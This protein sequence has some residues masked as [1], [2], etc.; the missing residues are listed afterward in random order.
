MREYLFV[1]LALMLSATAGAVVS[2]YVRDGSSVLWTYA[3]AVV[4]VSVW[5]WQS[6]YSK[7]S[8]TTAS[9][10]FDFV[11]NVTWFVTLVALGETIKPVHGVGA[12]FLIIGL[13]LL[14]R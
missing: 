10:L 2:R 6:K 12:A 8:L 7:M 13:V 14:G 1:S 9:L 11:Y 4:S 3:V 5:A